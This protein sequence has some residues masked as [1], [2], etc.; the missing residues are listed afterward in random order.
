[1]F[2]ILLVLDRVAISKYIELSRDAD[3][4]HFGLTRS[5]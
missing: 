5:H 2:I 4:M 3:V 1:V